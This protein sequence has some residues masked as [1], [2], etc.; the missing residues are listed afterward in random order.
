MADPD[1][2]RRMT[3]L[4]RGILVLIVIAALAF[5]LKDLTLPLVDMFSWR[6]ASTAM[7]ADNFYQKSWNIFYP[8]VSWTGPGPSYQGREFQMVSY[9]VAILY[10][11]FGWHDWF[12]RLV[13][14]CFST[15]TVFSL[16]RLTAIVWDEVHA[17]AAGL[18]YA[19]MPAAIMIDSSFLPDP[20]MLALVTLGLW[21][22]LRYGIEERGTWSLVL[23]VAAFSFGVLNK[24][25]GIAAV[26]VI[27][28]LAAVWWRRGQHGRIGRVILA[29]T[30]GLLVVAL[31]CG[32]AIHLGRTYPPYHVA[33]R[34]YLWDLGLGNFL[35]NRFYVDDLRHIATTWFYGAPFI[36]LVALGLWLPPL[37]RH[38]DRA[39]AAV[40]YAWLIAGVLAYLVAAREISSN[41]WNLHILSAPI[42]IFAGRGAVFAVSLGDK[43]SAAILGLR[44]VALFIF[45]VATASFPLLDVMKSRPAQNALRLGER[46]RTIS[47]PGDLVIAISPDVGDPVA[48]Y[49]SR[50]H[51][52]V[53]P[54]A[55][56]NINWTVF[57]ETD[58]EAIAELE[59]LRA[60]G[61][62][63]FG[64]VKNAKDE[65]G[66]NFI[67]HHAGVIGHLNATARLVDDNDAFVIYKL[68]E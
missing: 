36:V 46:L 37:P 21:L 4:D 29:M 31:Y 47:Q 43:R 15:V 54:P 35:A 26:L 10:Q 67:T 20:A 60:G 49:Y 13:A 51:G 3:S 8:Q 28:Y 44:S 18:A 6:E 24:L 53:F 68:A 52:W 65:W 58:G 34:G 17:H 1:F 22:F 27:V 40:P 11:L 23:A 25:P 2:A 66:R 59:Q 19:V 9:L 50:R 56:P 39:L 32:W 5:R 61:A 48:I 55:G 57:V 16:H 41:P 63:W 33:G 14:V 12:G 45:V 38:G 64:A 30:V 62:V 42:A 7:M